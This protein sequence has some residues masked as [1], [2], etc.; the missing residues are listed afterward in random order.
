M[1]RKPPSE[2]RNEVGTAASWE[3]VGNSEYMARRICSPHTLTDTC[4]ETR[5]LMSA[6]A[7]G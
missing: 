5:D 6:A 1:T 7:L 2:K 3:V 4:A